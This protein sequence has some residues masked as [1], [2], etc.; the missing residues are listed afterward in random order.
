MKIILTNT[1]RLSNIPAEIRAKLMETLTFTN[2]KWLENHRM[3]RWN[4]G[5]PKLLKFYDKTRGGGLWIPRGYMRQLVLLCRRRGV[6]VEIED[7][8]RVLTPVAF[9]FSGQLKT[10]QSKAVTVMLSRDFGTL[11]APTGSGKTV[12]ALYMIARRRQPALIVV[13]TKDLAYQWMERAGEFLGIPEQDVGFIGAGK[14]M[15][16]KNLPWPWFNLCIN[17][18]KTY[19]KMWGS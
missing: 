8:R 5:T 13:H 19:P 11:N 7:R 15:W 12:M 1:L 16:G 4:R 3:G 2:P 9:N 18:P 14:K 17:V 6:G 10:F